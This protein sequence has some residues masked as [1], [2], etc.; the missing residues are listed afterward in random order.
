MED[1]VTLKEIS[2]VIEVAEVYHQVQRLNE[3]GPENLSSY[4]PEV[5]R[6]KDG[7][8][9]GIGTTPIHYR[10]RDRGMYIGDTPVS[11]LCRTDNKEYISIGQLI[12]PLDTSDGNT[13]VNMSEIKIVG[14]LEEYDPKDSS[15][16]KKIAKDLSQPFLPFEISIKSYN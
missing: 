15:S 1:R 11:V 3:E 8:V 4:N 7:K 5:V 6:F 12:V 9:V 13:V 10:S 16:I 14:R 2:D